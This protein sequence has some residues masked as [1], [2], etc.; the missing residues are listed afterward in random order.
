MSNIT[1]QLPVL[2]AEHK[3][4]IDVKVNGHNKKYSTAAKKTDL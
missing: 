1:I 3:I 2:D 4:E